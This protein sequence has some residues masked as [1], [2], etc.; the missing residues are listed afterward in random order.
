MPKSGQAEGLFAG[1][2]NA[3]VTL[4]QAAVGQQGTVAQAAGHAVVGGRNL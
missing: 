1:L 2:A 3:A 4:A